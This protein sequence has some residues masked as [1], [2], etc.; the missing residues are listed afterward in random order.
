MRN[1]Q[2]TLVEGKKTVSWK[3]RKQ[4]TY[5]EAYCRM[6]Q[7]ILEEKQPFTTKQFVF[8]SLRARKEREKPE[9]FREAK[10]EFL[11]YE[12]L[13]GIIGTLTPGEMEQTFPITKDYDGEKYECKDY[14][15]T[16]NL[17]R[18]LPPDRPIKESMDVIDF[19]LDYQNPDIKR[20]V[21][22]SMCTISALQALQ[23]K[24]TLVDYLNRKW[25]ITPVIK[26]ADGVYMDTKTGKLLKAKKCSRKPKYLVAIQGRKP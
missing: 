11:Y 6:L 8:L 1:Q 21:I 5:H 10:E 19:L 18:Q 7:K 22:G 3:E 4:A 14:F 25:G 23:G 9:T 26:C 2:F 24:E 17:L 16:K 12:S 15:S 20:F 13:M